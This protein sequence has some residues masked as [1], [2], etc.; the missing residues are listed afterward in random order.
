MK[1]PI[2]F[3]S[4]VLGLTLTIGVFAGWMPMAAFHAQNA[5]IKSASPV[6]YPPPHVIYN[7][8]FRNVAWTQRQAAQ[9]ERE[10]K[11]GSIYQNRYQTLAKLTNAEADLLNRVAEQTNNQVKEIEAR[12]AVAIDRERARRKAEKI[13][14]PPVLTPEL[15]ALESERKTAIMAGVNNLKQQ[16]GASRFVEFEMF[17]HDQIANKITMSSFPEG[18][19]HFPWVEEK[20]PRFFDQAKKGGLK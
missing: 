11:D 16:M 9:S 14:S 6:K 13:T 8:M 10:G 12:A 2:I 15:R 19:A 17:V 18:S 3:L 5:P 20:S 7:M 4:S 1:R